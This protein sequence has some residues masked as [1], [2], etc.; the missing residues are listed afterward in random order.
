[1]KGFGTLGREGKKE[2]G[3]AVCHGGMRE[4][5]Q[6]PGSLRCLLFLKIVRVR[7]ESLNEPADGGHVSRCKGEVRIAEDLGNGA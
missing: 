6:E 4:V 1:M 7:G 3:T 2:L 5:A